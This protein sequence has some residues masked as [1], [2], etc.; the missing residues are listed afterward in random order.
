M[1]TYRKLFLS[2]P[3]LLFSTGI[4]SAQNNLIVSPSS[5]TFTQ[6]GSTVPPFQIINI[7][8]STGLNLRW[9]FSVQTSS[10]VSWFSATQSSLETPAQ[11]FVFISPGMTP[12][13]YNGNITIN[14]PNATPT[15]V[16]VPVTLTV[17][18][19][20]QLS[21]NLS[22]LTFTA[23]SNGPAPANQTLQ[24][25]SVTG[26][27]VPFTASV[28][29]ASGGNWLVANP[30][31][32]TTTATVTVGVNPAGVAAGTYNGNV[33][34]TPTT[35]A[36]SPLQIPV[37]FNV[38]ATPQLG[39]STPALT[40][41]WQ[42]GTA[43]PPRQTFSL[44]STGNAL[45]FSLVPTVTAGS[46]LVVTPVSGT[47]LAN[48]NVDVNPSGLAAGSYT[49]NIQII[50]PGASNSPQNV[51]VT[52]NVSTTGFLNVTPASLAFTLQAGATLP[53]SQT[54]SIASSS[55][56]AMNFAAS[57]T[58]QSGVPWLTVLAPVS[59]TTPGTVS[60]ALTNTALTLA[61]G[62]YSGTVAFSSPG[63]TNPAT[64]VPVTLTVTNT[65]ALTLNP[66]STL[67]FVY[68]T[69]R[70]VPAGQTV[71]VNSTGA[72][73]SFGAAATTAK[74]GPW[75]SVSQ[76][77]GT[78]PVTLG[79]TVD[80]TGLAA[81]TY[82]GTVTITQAGITT[83]LTIPVKLIVS[84]NAL[85]IVSPGALSFTFTPGG[86]TLSSQTVNLASTSDALNFTAAASTSSGGT[87]W[88]TVGPTSGSTPSTMT[89]VVSAAGLQ[90]GTYTGSIALSATGAN[91]QTIPVTVTVTSGA[92]LSVSPA[93]LT[94]TQA[95]GGS[96][97]AAQ[98]LNIA[99]SGTAIQFTAQVATVI[100][101]NWLTVN[102][103]SGATPGS[104]SVSVSGAGLAQGTYT[105]SVTIVG[106][107]AANGPQTVPVTFT[108]GP[109]QTI[110]V[111]K[112]SLSYS[113]QIGSQAPAAQ[114]VNVTSTGGSLSF[115][116]TG[117]VTSGGNWLTLSSSSGTTPANVTVSVNPSGLAPGAYT[118]TITVASSAASN[119][120]LTINVTLTVT[121]RAAGAL[122]QVVNAASFLPTP[123]VPGLIVTFFGTG[124][125][126][127]TGVSGKITNG[128]LESSAGEVRVL[129]DG[130]AAPVLFASATQVNAIVPYEMFGRFNTAVQ[131][132]FQGV[133]SN[134]ITL[135]VAS[136]SPGIFTIGGGQG[137]IINQDGRVNGTGA[138]APRGSVIALFATGE[139][140]TTPNGVNGK[141]IS[142]VGD[143]KKPLQAVSATI[144]GIPA[145]VQYFGSA[146]T[147]V[148]GAL[149][150]NLKVPDNAPT[151][152]VPIVIT[153]GGTNSQPGVTVAIQ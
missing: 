131:V 104:I 151:G 94:F 122:Q 71:S 121:Q 80:P 95:S 55:T 148:S 30:A 68:Q 76:A 100:G 147:L 119:S 105:G 12:G 53:A 125:G 3:I 127:S 153:V 111:D 45:G 112:T 144:G 9:S 18:A 67:T 43:N 113:F 27:P 44:S 146:P 2:I 88:L 23:Q 75:L 89:V 11:L 152:N 66:S 59:G 77:T 13:T 123:A 135:Q 17:G 48:I 103:T 126:P 115:T 35:G 38:T 58:T 16:V 39:V 114:A 116:P 31:S 5:L 52:L 8:V 6:P 137:A 82:D 56:T 142:T 117:A 37:T 69:G 65:P 61:P 32:A 92:S 108:V 79:I 50:A 57:A 21:A 98:T 64:N 145:E 41:N 97:P 42:I 129:F 14:V 106:T 20:T 87:G 22:S 1:P 60:I 25:A 83:G 134:T 128:V 140:Q 118:G 136:A 40:F 132:E 93:S 124:I 130:I 34:L 26:S 141:I 29:T 150:V 149:Q 47:T 86:A 49:G 4:A 81:D 120:P 62:T 96:A 102:P 138:A 70:T 36:A 10:G 51:Q 54:L 101:G 85:M 91:S 90:T 133:V 46:W 74:G 28:N 109:P 72:P 63:S 15:Q 99:S 110:A 19:S 84:A 33:I 7:S 107:G 73:I 78:T 139:G 24:V 143:L